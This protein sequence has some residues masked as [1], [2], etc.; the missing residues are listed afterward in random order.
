MAATNKPTFFLN[1]YTNDIPAATTFYKALSFK[2]QTD[3][4][5]STTA[6]FTLPSPNE[7]IALMLL[8][9]DKMKE[10]IRPGTT[11]G[12]AAKT[13]PAVYTLSAE[14]KDEVEEVL[15]RAGKAGAKLDPY[16]LKD[17]GAEH[18]MYCRSFEDP[19]GHI[20]EVCAMPSPPSA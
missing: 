11:V 13:T 4:C 18:G 19:T 5:D 10:F 15:A 8:T 6:S 20:W 1:L 9:P 3:W 14:S 2:H 17:Y 16:M 12:D 7:N